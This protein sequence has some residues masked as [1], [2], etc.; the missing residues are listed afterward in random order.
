LVRRPA[1]AECA[2][3][4]RAISGDGRLLEFTGKNAP[5]GAGARSIRLEPLVIVSPRGQT[6]ALPLPER[7]GIEKEFRIFGSNV[8]MVQSKLKEITISQS[9]SFPL[10]GAFPIACHFRL[11]PNLSR[12]QADSAHYHVILSHIL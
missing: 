10:S 3:A 5:H 4:K 6:T 2:L 9:L 1:W 11:N 7:S 12:L 8:A